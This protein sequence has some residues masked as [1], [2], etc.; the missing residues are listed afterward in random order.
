MAGRTKLFSLLCE[1]RDNGQS[2]IERENGALPGLS[3]VDGFFQDERLIANASCV[4][5]PLRKVILRPARHWIE[6]NVLSR[7]MIPYFIHLRRGDYVRWPSSDYPAVLP[8][9][10]YEAQMDA[11]VARDPRAQFLIVTDD[12]PYAQ[13]YFAQNPRVLICA[14]SETEDFALMTQCHGGGILSASSFAWMA[15]WYGRQSYAGAHYIA[16]KFWAGWRR[17]LWY[18]STINTSW[19]HYAETN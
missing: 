2:S 19:L 16:P 1:S 14:R 12:I 11:V 3:I 15:A 6:E 8:F 5:Y 9:A 18:P 7:G 17:H 13:E 4:D 10:W